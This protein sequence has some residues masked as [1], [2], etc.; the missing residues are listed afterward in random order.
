VVWPIGTRVV[1]AYVVVAAEA[2]WTA[3]EVAMAVA[4]SAT[5]T[6]GAAVRRSADLM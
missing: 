6:A 3:A 5:R 2:G 1:D 4:A